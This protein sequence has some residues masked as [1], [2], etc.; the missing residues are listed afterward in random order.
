MGQIEIL[1]KLKKELNKDIQEESQVVC[2][3][4]KIRKFLEQTNLQKNYKYIIFY[5]NW[6]LHSKL[7]RTEP[8]SDLLREV[9]VMSEEGVKFLTFQHFHA[10]LKR[11]FRENSIQ[12]DI[13][14][15]QWLKF[16]ELLI[17]IYS[18]TPVE[19]YPEDKKAL[20]IRRPAKPPKS[21]EISVAYQITE[22]KK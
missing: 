22:I 9:T 13:L 19:F 1:E 3:L 10:D 21:G 8:V 17:D 7:E 12:E 5:C 6:A 11:F 2:I 14:D 18:D 20:T 15:K 4:S 16:T